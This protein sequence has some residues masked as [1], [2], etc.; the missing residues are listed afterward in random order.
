MCLAKPFLSS[1]THSVALSP[2]NWKKP[3]M[4]STDLVHELYRIPEGPWTEWS[5]GKPISPKR[6]AEIL[7]SYGIHPRKLKTGSRPNGY[8]LAQFKDT[9]DRYLA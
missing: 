3:D 8:E 5:R 6:V 9:F 1:E 4:S 2:A 7:G